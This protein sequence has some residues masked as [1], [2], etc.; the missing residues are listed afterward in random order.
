M[1]LYVS[2]FCFFIAWECLQFIL[3]NFCKKQINILYSYLY[4]MDV[5]VVSVFPIKC[6]SL[7]FFHGES[8]QG[9]DNVY[10][11]MR[12]FSFEWVNNSKPSTRKSWQLSLLFSEERSRTFPRPWDHTGFVSYCKPYHLLPLLL[13]YLFSKANYVDMQNTM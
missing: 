10:F 1:W 4:R 6:V 11:G 5:G 7:C 8:I 9:T 12:D 3:Y 2:S 13:K